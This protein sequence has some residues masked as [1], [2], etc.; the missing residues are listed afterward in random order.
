MGPP[1]AGRVP[2]RAIQ[3][4]VYINAKHAIISLGSTKVL[5]VSSG[6][7]ASTGV[8]NAGG[9]FVYLAARTDGLPGEQRALCVPYACSISCVRTS[10]V[11]ASFSA[12]Q[13]RPR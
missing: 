3:T 1:V 9:A 2:T 10:C 4:G 7:L 5:P 12:A 13:C 11:L 6:G 8:G